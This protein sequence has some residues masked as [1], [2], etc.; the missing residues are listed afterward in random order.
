MAGKRIFFVS[1]C[2]TPRD[3]TFLNEALLHMTSHGEVIGTQSKKFVP[4]S[5]TILD[6]QKVA[7]ATSPKGI[8]PAPDCPPKKS[9]F[10]VSG[11]NFTSGI[12]YHAHRCNPTLRAPSIPDPQGSFECVCHGRAAARSSQIGRILEP[13]SNVHASLVL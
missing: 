6:A 7:R 1:S 13:L 4:K 10:K 11:Q 2:R 5:G 9:A 8:S 3:K 12:R